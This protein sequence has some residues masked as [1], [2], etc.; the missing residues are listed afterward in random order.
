MIDPHIAFQ[1][2]LN[3]VA[4]LSPI[5]LSLTE[6]MGLVLAEE[7]RAEE[8]Y[9]PFAAS[10]VDGW[11]VVAAD[12][13]PRRRI[14]EG[15]GLAG[16]VPQA[17]VVPGT[18]ARVMTGAPLP[19]GSDAVVMREDS[20][21]EGEFVRFTRAVRPGENVRP[22]GSDIAAG[23]IVLKAG[24]PLGPAEIGLLATVGRFSVRVHPRPRVAVLSTG[25]ELVE[26]WEVP[27]PGQIRDSNRYALI[28]AVRQAGGEVVHSGRVSDRAEDLQEE[29]RRALEEADVLITSGG[30]SE[31]DR[32]LVGVVLSELGI[33]HFRRVRQKPGKPLTFATVGGKPCFALPGNPVSALVSFELYVRPA[34]RRM[35]GHTLLRRPE[36]EVRLRHPVRPDPARVEFVRAVVEREENQ[37]WA[38]TTGS[39]ASSRLLSLTGA[40][41]LLRIPPGPPLPEGAVVS[42]I[43]LAWPEDH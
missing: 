31:G 40:N 24:T 10:T 22:A 38:R 5:A 4:P 29:V 14:L 18:A 23:T 13:S 8:N 17:H 36:V 20:V 39:Q 42:A 1:E 28:A 3:H 16:E 2:I 33:V 15:S 43:L 7:V 41:A 6:A 34:L 37:W 30:V 26:P 11:A 12:D 25:D 35:A 9:P 32:D 19:P 27:G 21:E